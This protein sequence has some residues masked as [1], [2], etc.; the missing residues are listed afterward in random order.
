MIQLN[1]VQYATGIHDLTVHTPEMT[2]YAGAIHFSEAVEIPT[3]ITIYDLSGRAVTEERR[4]TGSL[5]NVNA[6]VAAGVY[7]VQVRN[8]NYSVSKKLMLIK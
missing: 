7:V 4:F 3:V 1:V 8:D 2:Y 5:W 6:D